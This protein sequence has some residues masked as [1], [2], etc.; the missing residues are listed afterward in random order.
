MQ[1]Q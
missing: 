1:M